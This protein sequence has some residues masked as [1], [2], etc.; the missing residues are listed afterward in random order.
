MDSKKEY[1]APRI[2]VLGTHAEVVLTNRASPYSDGSY[3]AGDMVIL[4]QPTP[5]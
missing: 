3:D 4:T 2:E 1:S 5:S